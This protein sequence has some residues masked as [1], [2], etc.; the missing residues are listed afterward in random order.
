MVV[1]YLA[2]WSP[3]L[4]PGAPGRWLPGFTGPS[5]STSLD[6]V[7]YLF[8]YWNKNMCWTPYMSSHITRVIL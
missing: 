1:P 8:F 6:K 7:A 2:T 3:E 5:P 4:A